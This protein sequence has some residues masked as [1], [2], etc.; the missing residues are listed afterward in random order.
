MLREATSRAIAM[1]KADQPGFGSRIVCLA[2]LAGLPK[3]AA[4]VDDPPQS[5]LSIELI[6]A[7][8]V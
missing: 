2:R 1:V 3:D 4:D 7:C 5:G 8:V 6:T